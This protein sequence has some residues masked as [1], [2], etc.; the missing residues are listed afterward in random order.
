MPCLKAARSLI[1]AALVAALAAALVAALG[2]A[3]EVLLDYLKGFGYA[4]VRT[5]VE[6][7]EPI[8]LS[9]RLCV[10]DASDTRP[11]VRLEVSVAN[12]RDAPLEKLALS[13]EALP[14]E[15][16]FVKP[17]DVIVTTA[18]DKR[19]FMAGAMLQWSTD[20]DKSSL[21]VTWNERIGGGALDVR[22][23]ATASQA[24]F[25]AALR[26]LTYQHKGDKPSLSPR[27]ISVTIV[28][29]EGVRSMPAT[30]V[31]NVVPVNDRPSLDLNGAQN[32]GDDFYVELSEVERSL[33]VP[34][35]SPDVV[36]G[37]VDGNLLSRATV[38]ITDVRD[39]VQDTQVDE[40][41]GEVDDVLVTAEE[42][43]VNN[44]GTSIGASFANG[45]LELTGSDLLSNYRKVLASIRYRHR[46]AF[47]DY[48]VPPGMDAR[49]R[50][51][52]EL[53]Y[54]MGLRHIS[55]TIYDLM[56]G[57]V[58]AMS[59]VNVTT[60]KRVGDPFGDPTLP[61]P[62][63]CNGRGELDVFGILG[64]DPNM[65]ICDPGYEG[66]SCE[67]HVCL[68]RGVYIPADPLAG[69][70][71]KCECFP[72]YRG[73]SCENECSGHGKVDP[74]AM[75]ADVVC[76]CDP[77]YVGVDCSVQCKPCDYAH[78]TCVLSGDVEVD[79]E[80]VGSMYPE[81]AGDFTS[82]QCDEWYMG[83]NC[84]AYCPC[85]SATYNNFTANG[86][87]VFDSDT[88][89]ATCECDEGFLGGSC[90]IACPP[91]EHGTCELLKMSDDDVPG[92]IPTPVCTCDETGR[93]QLGGQ[94]WVGEDCTI[95]CQQ[96]VQ[97]RCMFEDGRCE[98][99]IGFAGA[100]C[101]GECM[102]N[103][104]ITFLNSS[105]LNIASNIAEQIVE[106]AR[107]PLLT[108]NA[109]DMYTT[110][111]FDVGELYNMTNPDESEFTLAYC[112]CFF[113]AR[114][115]LNG[116]GFTGAFCEVDCP[117][118]DYEYGRCQY[119]GEEAFCDCDKERKNG[120][121][122]SADL[123]A[124][125][126]EGI[127]YTGSDC[128]IPCRPCFNGTC[129]M[130]PGTLGECICEAGY[131]SETCLIECGIDGTSLLNAEKIGSRGTLNRTGALL[132]QG[133]V[134]VDPKTGLAINT[135][136]VCECDYMWAGEL[137]SY[138]CPWPY[139]E[140]HGD[141]LMKPETDDDY[142]QPYH[143][144]ILCHEGWTGR[145]PEEY[146][147]QPNSPSMHL[148]CSKQC[149]PCK[150]G[151]CLDTG[152]CLCDYGIIWQSPI[153]QVDNVKLHR[154]GN[155]P[156]PQLNASDVDVD[157]FGR[158]FYPYIES[159][160]RC[161]VR[162][163]CNGN[164][165]YLNATCG[166]DGNGTVVNGTDLII[167]RIGVEREKF[168]IGCT[169]I[170]VN[171]T[172]CVDGV[173]LFGMAYM[174]VDGSRPNKLIRGFDH[175]GQIH[176][177][178]CEEEPD[179]E[180]GLNIYGGSCACDNVRNGRFAHPSAASL[181]RGSYD[182]EFQGW[183]GPTCNIPCAPC[184]EN[185]QCDIMTGDCKC[186]DGWNG[187]RCLT[188][189]EP[190]GNG[191]CLY[192][193]TC[194]CDGGRRRRDGSFALRLARDPL[195]KE[196]GI[197]KF[198]EGGTL[199]TMYQHPMY[200]YQNAIEDYLFEIEYEC[201]HR[202]D[203]KSRF[204]DTHLPIRPEQDYY[205]YTVPDTV[206][207][208]QVVE[209][210]ADLDRR[211]AHLKNLTAT[212]PY[213]LN[214]TRV[215]VPDWFREV[216]VEQTVLCDEECMQRFVNREWGRSME[217]CGDSWGGDSPSDGVRPHHCDNVKKAHLVNIANL[218]IGRLK[219]L[220]QELFAYASAEVTWVELNLD[221]RQA[222]LDVFVRGK[223]NGETNEWEEK[224]SPNYYNIWITHQLIYGS[225]SG[226]GAYSGWNCSIPCDKCDADHGTCQ[227]DGSCECE[228]GWYG[229]AC[230][231]RCDCFRLDCS[232][233][234]DRQACEAAGQGGLKSARSDSGYEIRAFGTCMRDGACLCHPDDTGLMYNGKDCFTPCEPCSHGVCQL[235]GSCKC[236]SG[237]SG[238]ACDTKNHTECLP[239]DYLH[240]SCQTD[241]TCLCFNGYTGLD[242]SIPCS[243]CHNG[244]CQIDGSCKCRIGWA[245]ADCTV[246][247]GTSLVASNFAFSDEGWTAYNNS[248]LGTWQHVSS[249]DYPEGIARFEATHVAHEACPVSDGLSWVSGGSA[250]RGHVVMVDRLP[251]DRK[252]EMMHF[253]A[254]PK[255][256]GNMGAA[257]NGSFIYSLH[258]STASHAPHVNFLD[259]HHAR[260]RLPDGYDEAS[261]ERSDLLLLGGAA[262]FGLDVPN[263][264]SMHKDDV[265]KWSRE[266]FPELRLNVRWTHERLVHTV[267]FYL[268]A[269]QVMLGIHASNLSPDGM[270]GW[271]DV[272][273]E[274]LAEAS[275][276]DVNFAFPLHEDA[277]WYNVPAVPAG[278]DW[279]AGAPVPPTQREDT[280]YIAAS[281][282]SG[283]GGAE[284][285][286]ISPL[287]SPGNPWTWNPY[288][289]SGGDGG[290]TWSHEPGPTSNLWDI[291]AYNTGRRV[292]QDVME[293]SMPRTASS[294]SKNTRESD[295]VDVRHAPN[296][297][298]QEYGMYRVS[299]SQ[300]QPWQTWSMPPEVY[301]AIRINRHERWGQRAT[302]EDLAWCLGSVRDVLLRADYVGDADGDRTALGEGELVQLGFAAFVRRGAEGAEGEERDFQRYLKHIRIYAELYEVRFLREFIAAYEELLRLSIC[303]GNGVY[304]TVNET[305]VICKCQEGWIGS[306]ELDCDLEC[307][308]CIHG[309]CA[310]KDGYAFCDCE[311]GWTGPICNT[312]CTE[313]NYEHSTCSYRV[314][315]PEK[316]G[317]RFQF[318]GSGAIVMSVMDQL[319]EIA[320]GTLVVQPLCMCSSGYGGPTCD[321]ECP[322]C[323]Y[324]ND[325]TGNVTAICNQ[326]TYYADTLEPFCECAPGF[327]GLLCELTCPFTCGDGNC[328][329]TM[330]GERYST[331]D[332]Q[333]IPYE[334][335]GNRPY[336]ECNTGYVGSACSLPCPY[337][338]S[339]PQF[340]GPDVDSY[341][342]GRGE[343][344]DSGGFS[345][346]QCVEGLIGEAC[347]E[348]RNLCG[349]RVINA[350][351][352]EVC[353]DGNVEPGDG[354]NEFCQEEAGWE[355]VDTARE[356]IRPI[357][358][359]ETVFF[360]DCAPFSPPPPPSPPPSPP[361]PPP[362][363]SPPPPLPPRPP[364]PPL[365]I[366]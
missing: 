48:P 37:D 131:S 32:A 249:D 220:R 322:P 45:T 27:A 47:W 303:S 195:F 91:C 10:V 76:I 69:I 276:C 180:T 284:R 281:R 36:V 152:E 318:F 278:F 50:P 212:I 42:L 4:P 58:S 255:F 156:Y 336:C 288:G 363:P 173:Y 145:P 67:N 38:E 247:V 189:C 307:P 193:G 61:T 360:S 277:P 41:T 298:R 341:C 101:E 330:K 260:E 98:C 345:T 319:E 108:P 266:H 60:V 190:C 294:L 191:K 272:P 106:L 52:S 246:S 9:S 300:W 351:L 137:C 134:G 314:K 28:D 19:L 320:N 57:N 146:F 308:P 325:E 240:G 268:E 5:F 79:R 205:R 299:V 214:R 64:K 263:L 30:I 138:E 178:I 231:R 347:T 350:D 334:T 65:C 222:L 62:A 104:V 149:N 359:V 187:Y 6:G 165:E 211:I 218:E 120:L 82:C 175:F 333:G 123:L 262:G 116:F 77:G 154:T 130:A 335:Q 317:K 228:P 26:R 304:E 311:F 14:G 16:D 179:P 102:G 99:D 155:L 219:F 348:Y 161:E 113:E 68:D 209:A 136:H 274:C 125:E 74:D 201:P 287:I 328:S 239:C 81:D 75:S 122:A 331:Y 132:G 23:A 124:G 316:M 226:N 215:G 126:A 199:R 282:R 204:P 33:S 241:G 94:G 3:P 12:A 158:Q 338:P 166:A 56:G 349:D 259:S 265:Y 133:I 235:D 248:C 301:E 140:D 256:R 112:S 129:N 183:A 210:V 182:Y 20:D 245:G 15:E 295:Y 332:A 151:T 237:W 141:C 121:K 352:G 160:H 43:E 290:E 296:H 110:G 2:E 257:Y 90:D 49:L 196:K 292:G 184:S 223:L 366:G 243:P 157:A 234:A 339:H 232:A 221:E 171:G 337:T 225:G 324:T 144:E 176:G 115:G 59:V 312:P 224:Q 181:P 202:E 192:D 252:H 44:T 86:T 270:G 315:R 356:D 24:L 153:T 275:R 364:P 309:E 147:L 83:S 233:S 54:T 229:A 174:E 97:G 203:C 117:P 271:K 169:G 289:Y 340:Q 73:Q 343:C 13:E 35:T 53:K 358:G 8:F 143:T 353:D 261:L 80:D 293:F 142:G 95:P 253:R 85:G 279:L 217:S 305:A 207:V 361:P 164:G 1:V 96:C 100:K 167:L 327:T 291:E 321:G 244:A 21:A 88:W 105:S 185:G 216:T 170:N 18:P 342:A 39:L 135:T 34:V 93:N 128:S 103:G 84:S 286:P 168:A 213:A 329:H 326:D 159:V 162:H 71:A 362:P 119:D 297:G 267:R 40:N 111:I 78:G 254:P 11:V 127:G 285:Q 273:Q 150:Y 70:E 302:F 172:K 206:A 250:G 107:F 177:G 242:C 87:C 306:N 55:I 89:T 51:S 355:C 63:F 46:G 118:C 230:D 236:N 7:G 357:V 208:E 17:G 238:P 114:N 283:G 258:L 197:H 109:A 194:L 313:C 346:C 92:D 264:E 66:Y 227:F 188:P 31:V 198:V 365:P 29:A 139:D 163:P 310:S 25:A 269:P 323:A 251:Q 72:G 22:T 200:N 344:V 148:N 186:F 280:E 354:C